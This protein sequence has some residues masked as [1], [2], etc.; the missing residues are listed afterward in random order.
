MT[1]P[2]FSSSVPQV[3]DEKE[4]LTTQPIRTDD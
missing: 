2:L 3:I 4:L 1:V